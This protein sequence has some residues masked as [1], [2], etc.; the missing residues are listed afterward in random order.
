[1]EAS[2]HSVSS[3]NLPDRYVKSIFLK[4]VLRELTL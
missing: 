4:Q 3:S 2:Q 1:M